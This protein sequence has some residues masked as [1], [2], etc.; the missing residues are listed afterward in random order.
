VTGDESQALQRVQAALGKIVGAS[1]K[2]IPRSQWRASNYRSGE[3]VL[4]DE[5]FGPYLGVQ[6]S[7]GFEF[8]V[9]SAAPW[10][11][12]AG[13]HHMRSVEQSGRRIWKTYSVVIIEDL[14]SRDVWPEVLRMVGHEHAAASEEAADAYVFGYI[15]LRPDHH[16]LD[17]P[18]DIGRAR[19]KE[20][21]P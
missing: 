5:P 8:A 20:E 9:A 2:A 10:A 6:D 12:E 7:P 3:P 18:E 15:S 16:S 11:P 4:L 1:V 21:R 19:R 13:T 14:R 17:I